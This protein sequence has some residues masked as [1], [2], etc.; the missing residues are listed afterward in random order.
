MEEG[1]LRL[2]CPWPDPVDGA[3]TGIS[4]PAEDVNWPWVEVVQ[5][6]AGVSGAQV[7][8][9]V[10]AGVRGRV[11]AGTGNGTLHGHLE[12]ALHR[13]QQAGAAVRVTTR[14][15]FGQVVGA[16][17]HGFPLTDG[18]SPVKARISLMLELLQTERSVVV[19]R[20]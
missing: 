12:A 20:G 13:A 17:A 7:D 11:V 4:L 14:C 1:R 16:P 18:L 9:L 19:H 15:P 3:F 8:A 6:H 5:S 2:A 10:Q